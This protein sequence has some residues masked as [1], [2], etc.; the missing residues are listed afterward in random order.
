M[1]MR[2]LATSTAHG[3]NRPRLANLEQ[4]AQRPPEGGHR[5]ALHCQLL[6][7]LLICR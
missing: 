3:A 7:G 6:A 5:A 1:Q 4:G 2:H